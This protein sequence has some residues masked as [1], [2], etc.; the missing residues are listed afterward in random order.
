MTNMTFYNHIFRLFTILP[1][2]IPYQGDPFPSLPM[3]TPKPFVQ[4][5][6]FPLQS[7]SPSSYLHNLIC[8]MT[9]VLNEQC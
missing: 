9:Q 3:D 1:T 7:S 2:V 5:V 4:L 6:Q 8:G